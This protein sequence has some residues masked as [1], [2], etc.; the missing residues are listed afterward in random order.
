MRYWCHLQ[1]K[2]KIAQLTARTATTNND[3]KQEVWACSTSFPFKASFYRTQSTEI[4]NCTRLSSRCHEV[5]SCSC[6]A[7]HQ[8]SCQSD[9]ASCACKFCFFWDFC[10]WSPPCWLSNGEK[11]LQHGTPK[12]NQIF[13]CLF[14]VWGFM[15]LAKAPKNLSQSTQNALR[16]LWWPMQGSDFM[17]GSGTKTCG[18]QKAG[19]LMPLNYLLNKGREKSITAPVLWSFK[20]GFQ[21]TVNSG[22]GRYFFLG[23][24]NPFLT[25]PRQ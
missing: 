24:V 15:N 17:R 19:V 10:E 7:H 3:K 21:L 5:Q 13:L 22:N 8:I 20:P 1:D 11:I 4:E 18:T 2:Y 14:G 23:P 9:G 12:V 6:A 16:L 25:W